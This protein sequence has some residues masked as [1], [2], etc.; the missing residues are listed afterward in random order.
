[1]TKRG[2]YRKFTAENSPNG[3]RLGRRLDYDKSTFQFNIP[4][5]QFPSATSYLDPFLVSQRVLHGSEAAE[6]VGFEPTRAMTALRAFQARLFDRSSTSPVL[7][8]ER[9][10]FEPTTPKRSTAFRERRLKPLG[11]L[12][13]VGHC[14]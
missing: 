14:I 4:F 3:P 9:V 8:A 7:P 2:H 10:G 11:H 6:R 5:L 12:S 13:I 1:M